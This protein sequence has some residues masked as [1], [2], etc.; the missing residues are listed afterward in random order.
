[1]TDDNGDSTLDIN[2]TVVDFEYEGIWERETEDVYR[3]GHDQIQVS[4]EK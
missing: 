2:D 3:F 1:M 4:K